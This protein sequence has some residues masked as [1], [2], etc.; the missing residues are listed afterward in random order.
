MFCLILLVLFTLALL[1]TLVLQ[2]CWCYYLYWC[3][4]PCV[5]LLFLTLFYYCFSLRSIDFQFTCY[6]CS[7]CI[8]VAII[9]ELLINSLCVGNWYVT[10]FK[11]L[12]SSFHIA[13]LFFLLTLLHRSFPLAIPLATLLF[14]HCRA[15]LFVLLHYFSHT[16]TL[17]FLHYL[18]H[19]SCISTPLVMSLLLH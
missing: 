12:C 2:S 10:F 16:I 14:S 9:V 1:F 17:F 11:L 15:V 4:S 8:S 18:H 6:C 19:F 3:C 5:L 7:L 13:T